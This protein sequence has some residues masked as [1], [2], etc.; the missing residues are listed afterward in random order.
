MALYP[1]SIWL[2]LLLLFPLLLLM[3]KKKK[4]ARRQNKRPPPSPPKLPI[5]GNLHQIGELLHQSLWR[6]SQ[7]YG[8]VML[9]HLGS[10]PTVILSSA[11]AAREAIKVH[12]LDCC[13]RPIMATTRRLTYNYKDMA[14]GPYSEYWREIRKIC[15]LEVFSVKRVQS[16]RS[17]REEEVSL[18][19]NSISQSSS[20]ATL[21]DLSEKLYSLTASIT[22]RVAYGQSFRG[23]DLDNEKFQDLVHGAE[24]LMGS[25]DASE[26]FP[27]VGWIMDKLSSRR[28]RLERLSHKLDNF[29]QQVIDLH[30][31]P[32]RTEQ[33]HKDII[34]VLLRIEREQNDPGRF[35]KDNI[36]AVLLNMFLGGVDTGAI[37]MAWAMAELVRN[38]RVMKKAQDEVRNFV[39]NRGKVTEEDT[40]QLPYLKMILKETLRLHPPATLLLPREAMKHFKIN[41]YDIYPK[42][43]LQINAWAI[44]R[45]PEYWKNPEE[46]S[47][48]RFIDGSIDYKGQHFEL[49]P[50]GAGRR[51]CPGIYMATSTIEH[52]LANLLYVF[53]WKLPY[54][55]KEE[56]IDMEESVGLSLATHKKTALNLV[57]VKVF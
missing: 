52:A 44:G 42:T 46:F 14:F 1:L 23:S 13:S 35:T 43:L 29:F 57:P 38:P 17:I 5:I 51:G 39:G 25:F 34:D 54:G 24:A 40:D 55:M 15:V 7:K 20:S 9:L 28:R 19:I 26:Y 53:D 31:S 32:D 11:E 21:V 37:T 4:D 30:L 27:Y 3:I 12:D 41:G 33:E 2:P 50:F 45:D 36:K 47:P 8:P 18:L 10:I 56:N 6:L 22:F 48:E 49:L 16:Y